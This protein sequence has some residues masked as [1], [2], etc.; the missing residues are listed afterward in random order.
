MWLSRDVCS[1]LP[2]ARAGWVTAIYYSR[3]GSKA[4]GFLVSFLRASM[5]TH[6]HMHRHTITKLSLLYRRDG[7]AVKSLYCSCR[8]DPSAFKRRCQATRGFL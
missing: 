7:S 1:A 5:G 6:K 3:L 2:G 4:P 8:E